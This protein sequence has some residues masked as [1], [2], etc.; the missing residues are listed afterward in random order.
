MYQKRVVLILSFCLFV[1]FNSTAQTYVKYPNNP[2]IDTLSTTNPNE[3]WTRWKT[4]PCVIHWGNDS[5]RMYYGTNNYGVQTQIGTAV[6]LD[7]NNWIENRDSAVVSTGPAGSWDELD[8][9]TPG[10]LYIPSNPD[11]TKYMLYYSGSQHDSTVLDT[12]NTGLYPIEIYQIGLAYSRDGINFIKYNDPTNDTNILYQNSDPVIRIPYTTGGIP[13]TINYLFSSVA[14]P[15]LM[16]DTSTSTFKIWY[17]GL[18]CSNPSCIGILDFRY[19]ILYSESIDGI[20][21]SAPTP[22]LDIGNSG[23]FDSA[24]IYAP[25]VIKIGAEYWMFYGGNT[26]SSG[27]FAFF[28]QKIGLAI[29]TDGVN[30]TKVPDNPIATN[31]INGT[32][33]HLGANYPSAILYKDTL[34]VYYSGMQDS[35]F[36]FNPNIGYFYLDSSLS[37]GYRN[38]ALNSDKITL[39][40]NPSRNTIFVKANSSVFDRI[41]IVDQAGKLKIEKVF[42]PT[43]F[44]QVNTSSLKN[45]LYIVSIYDEDVNIRDLKMIITEQKTD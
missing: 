26:Y 43:N 1:L 20:N 28:S 33:D 37:I 29:S 19:R 40:P 5:L 10:V 16:F 35:I 41:R 11:S 7:G 27:T 18:G 30:F 38:N 17:I 14:E 9:E 4:D 32:W 25:H 42:I 36:N 13:D 3:F 39:F 8:V 22:V 2:V 34:R 44:Y 24:L 15:S 31:G 12:S 45:G 23:D 6:S 21:W